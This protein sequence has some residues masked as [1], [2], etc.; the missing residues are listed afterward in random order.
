MFD[1]AARQAADPPLMII[2]GDHQAAGFVAL[3]DS[4]AVPIHVVGPRHLV[5]MIEAPGWRDGLLPAPDDPPRPMDAMRDL[6]LDAFSPP[7]HRGVGQ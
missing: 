3:D 7:R 4:F 6:I 5:A 1:Y 2:L